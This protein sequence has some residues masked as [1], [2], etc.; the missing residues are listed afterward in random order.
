MRVLDADSTWIRVKQ[1][2]FGKIV[3]LGELAVARTEE[4]LLSIQRKP[5]VGHET[6]DLKNLNI[7]TALRQQCVVELEDGAKIRLNAQSRLSYPLL[8][9][10]STVMYIKGGAYVDAKSRNR[11]ASL[12]IGTEKGKIM[13]SHVDFLIRSDTSNMK[14][15]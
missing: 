12:S 2:T 4:G 9:R 13:T 5:M 11:S 14:P 6:S 8:K 7:Y 15:Y 10:D 1:D 3:Q